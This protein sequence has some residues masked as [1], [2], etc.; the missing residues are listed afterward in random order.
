MTDQVDPKVALDRFAEKL[1]SLRMSLD[2]MRT[3]DPVR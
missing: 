3:T 1:A 2:S